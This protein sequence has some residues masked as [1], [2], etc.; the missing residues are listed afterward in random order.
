MEKQQDISPEVEKGV[1]RQ[2]D[3]PPEV[4]QGTIERQG[5]LSSQVEGA[6]VGTF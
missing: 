4:V 2:S 3:L 1:E 6:A 5:A